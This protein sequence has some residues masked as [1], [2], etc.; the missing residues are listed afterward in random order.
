MPNFSYKRNGHVSFYLTQDDLIMFVRQHGAESN[1]E[2]KKILKAVGQIDRDLSAICP[3]EFL[4][5][6]PKYKFS[7][8]SDCKS[9]M[10]IYQPSNMPKINKA[11]KIYEEQEKQRLKNVEEYQKRKIKQ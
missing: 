1:E 11:R 10:P 2:E 4:C 5:K 8:P 6:D 7:C 3:P 9:L